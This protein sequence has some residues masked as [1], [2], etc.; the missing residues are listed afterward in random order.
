MSVLAAR[1]NSSQWRKGRFG[2]SHLSR[3]EVSS[4]W[5]LNHISTFNSTSRLI[6][7][8]GCPWAQLEWLLWSRE[9]GVNTK[10]VCFSFGKRSTSLNIFPNKA[11]WTG[12]VNRAVPNYAFSLP[13]LYAEGWVGMSVKL[14][15]QQPLPQV[16]EGQ[17]YERDLQICLSIQPTFSLILV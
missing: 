9:Q 8:R 16:T 5:E 6:F 1:E 7:Q 14:A 13:R 10:G 3:L 4:D 2:F 15:R 12:Y 11:S 17:V